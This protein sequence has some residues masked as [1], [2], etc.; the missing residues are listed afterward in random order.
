MTALVTAAWP[1]DLALMAKTIVRSLFVD[2]N[3]YKLQ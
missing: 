1:L 3:K 2:A